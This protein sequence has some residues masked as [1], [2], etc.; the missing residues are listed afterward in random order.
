MSIRP[1]IFWLHLA[2]GVV[3]GL[4]I[5][6][7]SFTG[8]VF[9]F[10]KQLIAWAERESRLVPI[11]SNRMVLSID[12]LVRLSMEPQPAKRPSAITIVNDPQVAVKLSFGR[13]NSAYLNPY[14]GTV[15]P[16]SGAGMRAFMREMIEWH[17]FLGRH[18]EQ[19]TW[20]K[21]VTGAC[22][23]AFLVL[24]VTGLYLWWPRKLTGTAFRAMGVPSLKLRGKARDWNWHN[25]VGFWTA[26]V[27]I[28]LT[29]T[30][31]P[32]SYQWAG[33]LIYRVTGTA[34]IPRGTRPGG[35]AAP[36]SGISRPSEG[37]QLLSLQNLVEAAQKE[38][39]DWKEISIRLGNRY[40][41]GGTGERQPARQEE[42]GPESTYRSGIAGSGPVASAGGQ[43]S[44]PRRK[45]GAADPAARQLEQAVS[46][47]IKQRNA[48]P[49]F[50]SIQLTLDPFTGAVL[51]KETFS[52]FNLGRKVRSW[53][54]FLHTG[55][56]L[57]VIGQSV[58]GIASLLSLLLI[59]TGFALTWRRFFRRKATAT[60]SAN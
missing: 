38:I 23:A 18:D 49:L 39:P 32:I 2:A 22:N 5:A 56:A 11:E 29:A 45:P 60:R 46:I 42:G 14:T 24:A 58:A 33:N 27:L 43:R 21:A 53:T 57:G 26:P 47:N 51:K 15:Q 41:M 34:P 25:A 55:E 59:W 10:E 8:A 54:R 1:F 7:M 19:R 37:A 44:G 17:R 31:L 9:A 35:S 48:W 50:S 13:T 40:R 4:V 6:V 30:A 3:A 28:V 16:A 20:G 52:D 12:E 36:S